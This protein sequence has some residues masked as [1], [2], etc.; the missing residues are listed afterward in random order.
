MMNKL[1]SRKFWLSAAAFLGSIG[2]TIIGL[3]S[4]N[5]LVATTGIVCSMLSSA[6]YSACEA[7]VDGKKA[8]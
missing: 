3:A 1:K 4:D 7:Y 6:I 2:T 5:Q 8:E